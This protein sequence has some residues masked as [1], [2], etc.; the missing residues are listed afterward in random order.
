MNK[1]K[2]LKLQG[3]YR[4][5]IIPYD[6]K[7]YKKYIRETTTRKGIYEFELT[8]QKPYINKVNEMSYNIIYD[9]QTNIALSYIEN[10]RQLE[11]K[12][13]FTEYNNKVEYIYNIMNSYQ[14]KVQWVNMVYQ[15]LNK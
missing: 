11:E 15:Y 13:R 5:T 10:L 8:G 14:H 9:S 7:E 2:M 1:E 6:I 12:G 3:G 4:N